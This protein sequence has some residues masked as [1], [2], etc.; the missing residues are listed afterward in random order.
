MD[1]IQRLNNVEVGGQRI[2]VRALDW[3]AAK[4]LK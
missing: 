2:Q 4:E 3:V 1:A